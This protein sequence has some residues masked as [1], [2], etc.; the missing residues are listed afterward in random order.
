MI[1]RAVPFDRLTVGN[2]HPVEARPLRE[3]GRGHEA[4]PS[5]QAE[6]RNLRDRT[7]RLERPGEGGYAFLTVVHRDR[8]NC[9]ILESLG[10]GRGRVSTKKDEGIRR[11]SADPPGEL[12]HLI[13]L[14]GV[15]EIP[16]S[17]G[18]TRRT[19]CSIPGRNLRST[20]VG[21]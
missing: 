16:T 3:R 18:R 10:V 21:S 17:C 14:Q 2:R 12:E 13:E 5:L 8:I 15:H 4:I 1:A 6:S 9:G 19:H 11:E 20:I 7:S